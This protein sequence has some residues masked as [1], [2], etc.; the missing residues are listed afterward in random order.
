MNHFK[1]KEMS[2]KKELHGWWPWKKR[3]CTSERLLINPYNGCSIGCWFCY[4]LSFPG[5]F[6]RFF[7]EGVIFVWKDF[8]RQVAQQLDSINVASCGYLSP[9]TDPFQPLNDKYKLSERII[10]IF[11][12]R[13]IPIEFVTK[14]DVPQE[15]IEM[16]KH[17]KHSFGQ[18]TILTPNDDLRKL[19]VPNGA[20]SETLFGC[21]EKLSKAGVFS[22]CRIDPIF[23]FITDK[24]ED[25]AKIVKMV[26]DRGVSHIVAS[27]L[28]IPKKISG[29]ILDEIKRRFGSSVEWEYK[30]L[31]VEDIGHMMNAKIDY[32]KRVFDFLRNMCEKYDLTFA[33]C[34]EYELKNGDWYGLN[35]EFM[36]SRNCEGIDIPIYIRKGKSFVPA[37]ECAG[38]CLNCEDAKCGIDDLAMGGEPRSF[39]LSDYRRWS[40]LIS[41]PRLL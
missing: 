34:M 25:L 28:D 13:N 30:R 32:R 39:K 1:I 37:Y 10:K 2:T 24:K 5:N 31:Y 8:D 15:V 19:L 9:V 35:K 41:S 18:I 26:K 40:K 20:S 23:P 7:R 16:M 33:L 17:Q 22:V 29:T 36:S 3:E 11:V 27:V 21:L 14:S 6:E 12:E 4:T 38:N